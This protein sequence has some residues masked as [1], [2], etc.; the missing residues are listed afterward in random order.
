VMR[1][2]R[3]EAMLRSSP[4]AMAVCV[5]L[6]AA[7]CA[8]AA[9]G[10][11]APAG[12]TG[13]GQAIHEGGGPTLYGGARQP[14]SGP[15]WG[16]VI[17]GGAGT[18]E[19]GSMS[20]EMER[21]YH[22]RLEEALRAGHAVLARGG[23]SLDAVVAAINVMEDSPL[24]NAGR[25]AVFTAD[26][27]NELDASIMYGPTRAAGAVAGVTRVKNPIN[28][29]RLVMDRSPHVMMVGAGAET[30]GEPLGIEL[31]DPAYF[32]TES[33]WRS[34]E[35]AREAERTRQERSD[36]G[37]RGGAAV[38]AV[39][40]D[41]LWPTSAWKMGTVGAVALDREGNL[42]AGTSTGGMTNK[43]WGRVGDA[44]IIGA[45][46]YADNNCG[47]ISATGHGEYFIRSVVAYDI[48][49]ITQ[50][51]NV[52]MRDAADHVVMNKLVDFGGEG[53][54]VGLDRWGN[55]VMAFNSSGMYRGYMGPDG[56]VS[57][58]IYRD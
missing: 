56:R 22:A 10:A 43:R 5:L 28:L 26:G 27:R 42:A 17:H 15:G 4:L 53:G 40:G 11:A 16:I 50:Y 13:P 1:T 35:R 44:P 21:E 18:I 36:A 20:S 2:M 46:T 51:Q 41:D 49:A 54:V 45:G 9:G 31:V 55:P 37:G 30:F 14:G 8:P 57:T 47:G 23:S 25:G 24:F 12:T 48:C 6:L 32:H 29:A 39:A 58:A 33:R 3:I 34:L 7:G 19:R 38:A 52:P